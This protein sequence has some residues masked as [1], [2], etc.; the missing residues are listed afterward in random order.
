MFKNFG[1]S[2]GSRLMTCNQDCFDRELYH[3]VQPLIR[4]LQGSRV[5]RRRVGSLAKFFLFD[6]G[7]SISSIYSI[8][9]TTSRS[10]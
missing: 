5:F 9:K 3:D 4:S 1:L 10:K 7:Q 6:L 2:E 8:L